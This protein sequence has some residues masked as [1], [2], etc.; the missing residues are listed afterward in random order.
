MAARF[1][2]RFSRASNSWSC[3]LD[4]AMVAWLNACFLSRACP[5]A[6]TAAGPASLGVRTVAKESTRKSEKEKE[7]MGLDYR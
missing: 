3:S 2:R 7:A 1:L 5:L 4:W 6:A